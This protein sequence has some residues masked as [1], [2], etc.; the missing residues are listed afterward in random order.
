MTTNRQTP[1]SLVDL[2]AQFTC[3]GKTIHLH[4]AC[5]TCRADDLHAV[6]SAANVSVKSNPSTRLHKNETVC[7]VQMLCIY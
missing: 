7:I 4:I 3:K 1:F 5:A 6:H 2:N